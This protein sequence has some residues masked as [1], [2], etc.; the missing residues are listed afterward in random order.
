MKDLLDKL[1]ANQQSSF[2]SQKFERLPPRPQK[3][4]WLNRQLRIVRSRSQI[5]S[6]R[7]SLSIVTVFQ[8]KT[9]DKPL[10]SFLA[11]TLHVLAVSSLICLDVYKTAFLVSDSIEF[12]PRSA[13][14]GRPFCHMLLLLV[15]S[16]EFPSLQTSLMEVSRFF[17]SYPTC[18]VNLF[19]NCFA[20][21][22]LRMY[23]L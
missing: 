21:L 18:N 19:N 17:I 15:I 4:L 12:C 3:L 6:Q 9:Q 22:Q 8:A 2:R 16:I 11:L 20:Y 5:P 13:S 14:M 1:T 10:F 23:S 7:L